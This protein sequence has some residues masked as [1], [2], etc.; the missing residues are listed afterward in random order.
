MPSS[1]E[2]SAIQKATVDLCQTI[3]SHPDFGNLRGRVEGF[4]GNDSAKEQYQSLVEQGQF[5]EHRQQT[6]GTITQAEVADFEQKREAALQNP[7]IRSFLEAQQ[8][9]QVIQRFVNDYVA[10]TFELGRIPS[11]EDFHQGD[12]GS[13]CGCNH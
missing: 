5:L 7:V 13:G 2:E 9:I 8:E 1:L 4:L 6:G 10:K 11:E 3:T 12:C